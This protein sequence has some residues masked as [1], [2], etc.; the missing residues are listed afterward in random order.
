M[1]FFDQPGQW[2]LLQQ[3]LMGCLM[4]IAAWGG[5]V[6]SMGWSEEIAMWSGIAIGVFMIVMFVSASMWA[7]IKGADSIWWRAVFASIVIMF[8]AVG[9]T[10]I[11]GLEDTE[12]SELCFSA[13]M[14]SML[15]AAVVDDRRSGRMRH[16]THWL[17]ILFVAIDTAASSLISAWERLRALAG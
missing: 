5:I 11:A 6:V 9:G 8:L 13:G 15:L 14:A 17:G 7:A 16:W 12:V 2:L 3:A 1:A 4:V 10:V